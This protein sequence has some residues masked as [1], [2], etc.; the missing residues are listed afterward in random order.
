MKRYTGLFRSYKWTLEKDNIFAEKSVNKEKK[1]HHI[2]LFRFTQE[3]ENFSMKRVTTHMSISGT[4]T[5][6]F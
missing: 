4:Q 2:L 5:N 3:H 1:E 6:N